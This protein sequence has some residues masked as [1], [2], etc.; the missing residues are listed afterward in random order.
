MLKAH[1]ELIS[2]L[3][4]Q[5]AHP[6]APWLATR[7]SAAPRFVDFIANQRSKVRKKIRLANEPEALRDLVCEL[8]VAA[9]LTEE[10]NFLVSY[11]PLAAQGSSPDFGVQFKGH[12][13]IY[14]EVT[15]AKAGR[16][17]GAVSLEARLAA[18][19]CAKLRQLPIGT[20]ALL[21]LVADGFHVQGLDID[22]AMRLLRQRAEAKDDAFFAFR[23]LAGAKAFYKQ[24]VA[25]SAVVI[26]ST[27]GVP[28]VVWQH[29]LARHPLPPAV[30]RMLQDWEIK[31]MLVDDTAP[32]P[33]AGKYIA[34][35]EQTRGI[36]PGG[37]TRAIYAYPPQANG[38]GEAEAWVGTAVIERAAPYTYFA[39]RKRVHVPVRGN[40]L[41]LHFQDPVE[42]VEIANGRQY[43][44]DGERPV[45]V[46]LIDGTVLAFNL[47]VRNSVQAEAEVRELPEA[48]EIPAQLATGRLVRVIYAVSGPLRVVVDAEQAAVLQQDD[49]YLLESG[50]P[51]TLEPLGEG[52][53][54]VIAMLRQ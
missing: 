19:I 23:G 15:R 28:G 18:L 30:L 1:A 50:Q 54:V 2:Y 29:R 27:S 17:E 42:T 31:T 49:A 11:E 25:L 32:Q 37:T 20:P 38:P 35:A 47:I 43:A 21:V 9:L 16:G 24:V 3:C 52:A 12:T 45:T 7:F 40:G 10:R 39:D 8:A 4:G 44:F 22:A 36:W 53:T 46:E 51:F 14:V 41:R 26:L 13:T 48:E 33:A 6:L 5:A 34:H